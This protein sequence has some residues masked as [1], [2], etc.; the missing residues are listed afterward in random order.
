MVENESDRKSTGIS[1]P[2]KRKKVIIALILMLALFAGGRL[3]DLN[4]Y[5]QSLQQWI[6][7]FGSWGPIVFIAVYVLATWL[8]LPGIPF[9]IM[10]AFLFGDVWGFVTMSMAVT[11]AATS[12]FFIARYIAR[13]KVARILS[14]VPAYEK[15]KAM[16]ENNHWFA[17]PFIRLMPIFPFAVNNYAFGLTDISFGRYFLFSQ[18]VFIPMNAAFVFGA[19]SLYKVV[20]GGEISWVIAACSL[21]A[22]A[23][24]LALGYAAKQWFPQAHEE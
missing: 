8:L 5:L 18:V 23:A 22:A 17:I 15:V 20:T 13:D 21:L 10:A 7:H 4:D 11:L 1:R 24:V 2:R 14:Q 6:W 12:A 19:N 16:V 3:L 9:T